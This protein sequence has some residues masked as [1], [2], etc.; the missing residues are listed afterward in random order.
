MSYRIDQMS[1]NDEADLEKITIDTYNRNAERWSASHAFK[2]LVAAAAVMPEILLIL[3]T[4][5]L[6]LMHQPAWYPWQEEMFLK[7][8]LNKSISTI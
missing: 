1:V 3:V 5:I 7:H 4:I 2:K 6:V 8:I